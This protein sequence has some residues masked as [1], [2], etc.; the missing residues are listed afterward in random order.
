M[1][2]YVVRSIIR[3]TQEKIEGKYMVR[4]IVRLAEIRVCG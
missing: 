2:K 3:L 4:Y 1:R